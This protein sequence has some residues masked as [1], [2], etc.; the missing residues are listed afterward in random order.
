MP[1]QGRR[2]VGVDSESLKPPTL[3]RLQ[4]Q[5][6][7]ARYGLDGKPPRALAEVARE[8]RLSRLAVRQVEGML[9]TS[10]VRRA[11]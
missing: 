2:R 9:V 7:V 10:I 8:L 3:T 11:R 5:V 6:F 4:A 1:A